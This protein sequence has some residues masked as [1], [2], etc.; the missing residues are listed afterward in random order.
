MICCPENVKSVLG[1]LEGGSTPILDLT[2]CAAQQ[3]VLS[4]DRVSFSDKIMPLDIS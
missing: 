1:A 3:G 4:C 2:N